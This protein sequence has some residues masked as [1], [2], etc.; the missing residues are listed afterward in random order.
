MERDARRGEKAPHLPHQEN[1]KSSHLCSWCL[2]KVAAW[3][4][5]SLPANSQGKHTLSSHRRS[6]HLA[7]DPRPILILKS[8]KE[9]L[10]KQWERK[11]N[12]SMARTPPRL[13]LTHSM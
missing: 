11:N 1:R 7:L 3:L 10:W 6:T 12:S 4:S 2:L 8:E 9:N 5:T 13:Y